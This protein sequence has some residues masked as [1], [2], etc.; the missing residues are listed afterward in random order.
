MR[1]VL[2]LTILAIVGDIVATGSGNTE[3]GKS[4]DARAN[5]Q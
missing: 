5:E 2:M 3:E 1:R 4:K